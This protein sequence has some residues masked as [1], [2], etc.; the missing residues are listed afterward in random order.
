MDNN[1]TVR[2]VREDGSA[3]TVARENSSWRFL[4]NNALEGFS[5]ID[6]D[7][8]YVDNATTDG[9][10][11]TSTRLGRKDRTIS[12]AHIIPSENDVARQ[13]LLKF[14]VEFNTYK[15]YIT[16]YGRQL[17][18]EGM[19]YKMSVPANPDLTRLLTVTMTFVFENPYLRSID[20][21]GKDIAS[22]TPAWAFPWLC[23]EA[24]GVP[25]GVYNFNQVIELENKGDSIARPVITFIAKGPVVNPIINVGQGFVKLIDTLATDDEVVMNFAVLPPRITKNGVNCIGKCDR[26]STFNEIYLDIG[27]TE[28]S[29]DADDG[30]DNLS[31]T[32]K[33]NQLYAT[34]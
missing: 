18:C 3:F 8:S 16:Y 10:Q 32:I 25:V 34:I 1:L 21:F 19:L 14:F 20:D 30:A 13:S 15:I 2:F 7:V 17:W 27:M 6:G 28:V 9:G 4:K 26:T 29:Y 23:T 5:E 11:I 31:V 12:F 22:V 24:V 33:Y